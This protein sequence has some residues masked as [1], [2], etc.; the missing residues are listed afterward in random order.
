MNDIKVH[1]Y[2]RARVG[3]RHKELIEE[4]VV[5]DS[6]TGR[7]LKRLERIRTS[8]PCYLTV[9]M[10]G[11]VPGDCSRHV[12]NNREFYLDQISHGIFQH[13]LNE[14]NGVFT[15]GTYEAIVNGEHTN[16]AIRERE[17]RKEREPTSTQSVTKTSTT[18]T[19]RSGTDSSDNE[20]AKETVEQTPDNPPTTVFGYYQKRSEP[21]LNYVTDVELI[22]GQLTLRAKTRDL[23]VHGIGLSI[24]DRV[25][26]PAG[27]RVIVTFTKL[28]EET[29]HQF[30]VNVPYE[31]V[32]QRRS[33]NE[34][35]L[36]LKLIEQQQDNPTKEYFEEFIEQNRLR[37][38]YEVEDLLTETTAR[39][40]E[41]VYTENLSGLP[42]FVNSDP[43]GVLRVEQIAVTDGNSPLAQFFSNDIEQLDLSPL[44]LP[45]RLESLLAKG[46]EL[47]VLYR[48]AEGNQAIRSTTDHELENTDA[49]LRFI[50]FALGQPEHCIVKA[51]IRKIT[52]S[53]KRMKLLQSYTERIAE[54]DTEVAETF[55]E[56]AANTTAV[57]M[58]YDITDEIRQLVGPEEV[59]EN[60]ELKQQLSGLSYWE[61]STRC[62]LMDNEPIDSLD[63]GLFR[64]PNTTVFGYTEKRRESRYIANTSIK[65]RIGKENYGGNTI[66]I[67]ARG[68]GIKI[69]G[70][71]EKIDVSLGDEI[72]VHLV[73]LQKKRPTLDLKAVPYQV[74]HI[75]RQPELVLGLERRSESNYNEITG[76]FNEVIQKNKHKLKLDISE[77]IDASAAMIYAQT[78]CD[79]HVSIPFFISKNEDD[80]PEIQAVATT[81]PPSEL[82]S[83]VMGEDGECDFRFLARRSV[84]SS[85]Y[86]SIS[87]LKR[88]AI[89][90]KKRPP[91]YE[92][93]I[94]L[95]KSPGDSAVMSACTADF[96]SEAEQM[97]FIG[98]LIEKEQFRI[99]KLITSYVESVNEGE[100]DIIIDVV[101][102]S[103]RYRASQLDSAI[104]QIIGVGELVD[105]T[106]DAARLLAARGAG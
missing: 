13:G 41:R 28:H 70:D 55:C 7:F 24:K 2:K 84:V 21:R 16:R 76:F 71:S 78:L 44:C 30:L 89:R 57:G 81:E 19:G 43:E 105:I 62:H 18:S 38:K 37:Y 99:I 59:H 82:A 98:E 53:D 67:S 88:E 90:E 12:F 40:Y 72:H 23:S 61:H 96:E 60:Q 49:V 10:R 17:L 106:R 80:P 77:T 92:L 9:D 86:L 64:P 31:L 39:L 8:K 1:H 33:E 66:D 34:Y 6:E 11:K 22:C 32:A 87:E 14:H 52:K 42:F 20:A 54:H 94:Y 4:L 51:L 102:S 103:S 91:P 97:R 101:R 15:V 74:L 69:D 104:R 56:S 48:A 65:A 58:L 26:L 85:L 47:F 83:F 35:R 73:S 68:L 95:W 100:V 27:Q 46:E 36:M 25:E 50:R 3:A 75:E 63:P 93:E 5:K 45:S 29:E 79:S